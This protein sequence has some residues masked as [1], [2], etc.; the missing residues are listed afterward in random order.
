MTAGAWPG[1]APV[2][3]GAWPA[4]VAVRA[5]ASRGDG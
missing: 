4:P 3:A 1:T 2:T 5:A